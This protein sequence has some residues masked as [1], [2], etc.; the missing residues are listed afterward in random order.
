[1]YRLSFC[2]SRLA[3][4]VLSPLCLIGCTS[5]TT[6]DSTAVA[7]VPLVEKPFQA[8]VV[9]LQWINPLQR[10]DYPTEWQLLWTLGL[11]QPNKDDDMVKSDPKTFSK[12]QAIGIIANGND[13]EE[14]FKASMT[15]ISLARHT[16]ITHIHLRT[17]RLGV[18]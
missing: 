4:V 16:S 7:V 3:A 9:G 13:G 17:R 8:Q 10:R 2:L 14:T 15:S 11:A 5:V 1:M 12:L 6:N 18:N